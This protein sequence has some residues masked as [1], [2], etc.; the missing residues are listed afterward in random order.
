MTRW[1]DRS[2]LSPRRPIYSVISLTPRDSGARTFARAWSG[3]SDLPADFLLKGTLTL[4]ELALESCA[5]R[6]R[7]RMKI[8]RTSVTARG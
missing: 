3:R 4:L 8:F 5:R 1:S 7:E 6:N 2:F